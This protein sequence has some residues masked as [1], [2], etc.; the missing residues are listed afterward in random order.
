MSPLLVRRPA[1][2]HH[3]GSAPV[4]SEEAVVVEEPLELRLE[5]QT[6]TVT[7]RTPGHDL[8]LAAGFLLSEGVIDGADDLVAL[9]HV[10]DPADPRGNT[11][12]VVLAPGLAITRRG[13][14]D[15]A[16]FA[17][18]ACGICGS[19]SVERALR[20]APPLP[21]RYQPDP[22]LVYTLPARLAEAQAHFADSGGLH[23]AALVNAAGALVLGREDIGR[24][25]AVDKVCG[26][27]LRADALPPGPSTLV[28]SSRLSQ[29]LVTKA[30]MAGIPALAGVGAPSSLAI[31]LAQAAGLCLIGFLR[32]GRFNV[33][34]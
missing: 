7:L 19:A 17:T 5:G 15:R 26:A 27:L 16:F 29:E 32:E 21:A 6:L 22:D 12:D 9:A 10:D 33:Y 31:E 2:R 34:A 14:V 25:N 4:E 20:A 13:K 28:V 11:V 24:H 1:W 23:A 8:D 30:L 18:S 3:K